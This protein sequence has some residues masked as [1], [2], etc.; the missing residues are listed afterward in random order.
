VLARRDIGQIAQELQ[1]GYDQLLSDT[2]T[3]YADGF[4]DALDI[5]LENAPGDS[6]EVVAWL[7]HTLQSGSAW[8][9]PEW[10]G[11]IARIREARRYL[12]TGGGG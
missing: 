11:V 2:E 5:I 7:I 4:Q 3:A 10:E 12:E 8:Q 1:R 9:A 6:G